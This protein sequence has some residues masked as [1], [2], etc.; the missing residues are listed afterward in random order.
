MNSWHELPH[1]AFDLETTGRDPHTARIVTASII[2][3]NGQGEILQ[4]H[5]WLAAVEEDIPAEAAAIHGVSTE[6]A[7]AEGRPAPEVTAEIAGV[8]G[9]MFAAGIPVLAFNACYD[10][11]VLNRECERFNLTAPAPA[12][13]IDPYILDKQV[14]RYRRGKRTLTALTEHYGVGFENAHT[15]A[16]DVMATLGVARAM[17]GRYPALHGDAGALHQAQIG[18]AGAQAASFQDYLRRKDPAAVVDGSWPARA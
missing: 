3:V 14:D 5:E 9:G 10:F 18:W 6:R 17:A 15:S 2:L 11:T 1:A 13:V 8:L 12:P 4:H 16:A 7:R